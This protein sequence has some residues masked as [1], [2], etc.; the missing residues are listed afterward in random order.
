MMITPLQN[1]LTA[2]LMRGVLLLAVIQFNYNI[3]NNGIKIKSCKLLT[4]SE[5]VWHL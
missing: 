1:S 3:K 5:A 4:S 2:S